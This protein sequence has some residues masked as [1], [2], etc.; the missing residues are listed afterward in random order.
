MNQE[1]KFK[2]KSFLKTFLVSFV[3]LM[4]FSIVVYVVFVLILMAV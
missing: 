2:V 3:G 1:T 4:L